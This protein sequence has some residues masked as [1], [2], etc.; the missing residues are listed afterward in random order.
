MHPDTGVSSKAMSIM[1]SF[2][3]DLLERIFAKDSKIT[4][5]NKRSTITSPEIQTAVRLLLS[6]AESRELAK[7]TV[8]DTL[9][10]SRHL[11]FDDA[12]MS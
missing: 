10:F 4:H 11:F 9:P 2:V 7:Q 5:H 8:S 12:K 3:N 1:I 6:R